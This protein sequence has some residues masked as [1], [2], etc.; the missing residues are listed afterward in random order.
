MKLTT[1]ESTWKV[2]AAGSSRDGVAE[3]ENDYSWDG[4]RRKIISQGLPARRGVS[5]E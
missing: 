1:A 4:R 5:L 3:K 2:A